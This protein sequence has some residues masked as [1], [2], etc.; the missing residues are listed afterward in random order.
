MNRTLF[1]FVMT[2]AS[3]AALAAGQVEVSFKPVDQL[4]DVGR[5]PDRERHV[6]ALSDHFKSLGARLPDGQVLK[7]EVLD[8]NM[9]GELKPFRRTDEVRVMRGS[10]DWPTLELRWSLG[11]GGNTLRSGQ[12]RLVD[13]AYQSHPLRGSQTGPVAY[14]ARMIDRW[15]DERVLAGHKPAP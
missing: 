15:F 14:E 11:S 10:A 8:V 7:V 13:M 12:D 2:L 1:A 6:Q 5:G 9:A 3:T 4:S